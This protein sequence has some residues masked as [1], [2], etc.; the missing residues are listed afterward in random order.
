MHNH[1]VR[2]VQAVL[3]RVK[4]ILT[5]EQVADLH[6]PHGIVCRKALVGAP[7]RK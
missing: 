4:P 3:Y 6:Q 7:T 5:G 2:G 1:P